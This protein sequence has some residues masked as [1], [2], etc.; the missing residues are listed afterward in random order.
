M[1]AIVTKYH[2]PTNTRGA[3][4]SA[5]AQAGRL[6]VPYDSALSTDGN[7]VRAASIFA[8]RFGW[9]GK[10]VGGGLP[11]PCGSQMA[12]VFVDDLS[13]SAEIK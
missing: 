11:T 10:I 7:H 13:P 1:Q 5:K 12:F 2:G 9:S 8:A 4:I 6:S 3:R